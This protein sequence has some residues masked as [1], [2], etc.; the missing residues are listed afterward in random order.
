MGATVGVLIIVV[1][2][3]NHELTSIPSLD[4]FHFTLSK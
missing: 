4:S 1:G 3:G 2:S